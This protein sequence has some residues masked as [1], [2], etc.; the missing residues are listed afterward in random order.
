MSQAA[1]P[2]FSFATQTG[3]TLYRSDLKGKIVIADFFFT[4]CPG[5]CPKMSDNMETIQEWLK[6]NDNLKSEY[7]LLS[8]TVDPEHDTVAVL[9]EYAME[10][11][12][13]NEMWKFV[14]G[15]KQELYSLAIDF[16]KLATR[17]ADQNA[18]EAFVHSE[19][20]VLIDKSGFIR[21]YYNGVDKESVNQLVNDI[22]HLDIEYQIFKDLQNDSIQ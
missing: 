18:E 1:L 4:T 8:H 21:G 14:T 22:V 5:I 13:D 7:L 17:E 20:F 10:R 15:S 12:A 9:K 16:Y 11:N 3:D 19:K 6:T 2:D